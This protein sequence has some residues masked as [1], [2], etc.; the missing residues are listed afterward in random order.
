M[1]TTNHTDVD[2][3]FVNQHAKAIFDT[4]N[5]LKGVTEREK[6]TLL[7]DVSRRVVYATLFLCSID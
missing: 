6:I 3:G 7:Y 5:A 4:R 1:G 2:Y